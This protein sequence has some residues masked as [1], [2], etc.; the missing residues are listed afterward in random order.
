MQVFV[1]TLTGRVLTVEIDPDATVD[2]FRLR[3]QDAEG[4]PPDQQRII[5]R[6]I[7]LEDSNTLRH[8]NIQTAST[9]HLF[10]RLRGYGP[11][12][13]FHEDGSE[14]WRLLKSREEIVAESDSFRAE[15]LRLTSEADAK[16]RIFTGMPFVWRGNSPVQ[17]ETWQRL[18]NCQGWT[19]AFG[20]LSVPVSVLRGGRSGPPFETVMMS[21]GSFLASLGRDQ[22]PRH[23]LQQLPLRD[24]PA[25]MA[26]FP[27][28]ADLPFG[29]KPPQ[30]AVSLFCGD[31]GVTTS[32]H[33]DRQHFL[34]G[35]VPVDNLF[36]CASGR[37]QFDLYRPAD[38]AAMFAR[39]GAL[40]PEAFQRAG[41]SAA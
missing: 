2:E 28:I 9:V 41:A 21:I 39:G 26:H 33:M 3:I 32:L 4:I 18:R 23:Y 19:A 8:Y 25:V 15:T 30:R 38:H 37:K 7:M 1:Q 31:A 5:F 36:F 16:H 6:G 24:Y 34:P 27:G 10:L 35:I 14:A 17:A 12:A 40:S 29:I 13:F 11:P 20:S 22:P